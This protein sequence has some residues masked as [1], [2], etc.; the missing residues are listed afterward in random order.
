[1]P[2]R[3]KYSD[4]FS[5]ILEDS[6]PRAVQDQM[7]QRALGRARRRRRGQWA[8][9]ICLCLALAAGVFAT[10]QRIPRH[11]EM[12][13]PISIAERPI[14]HEISSKPFTHIIATEA[15]DP[16]RI[17]ES[18]N[19]RIAIVETSRNRNYR[20][21]S[22]DQLLSFFDG[23]TAALIHPDSENARLVLLP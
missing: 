16:A 17:L 12:N 8:S 6:V 22:D 9:R 1:M 10:F 20:E 4:L 18:G 11:S 5:D 7:I 2:H 19:A 15:F 21:I 3:S 14:R 23:Q 13:Q